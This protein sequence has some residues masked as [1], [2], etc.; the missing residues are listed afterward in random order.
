MA[1]SHRAVLGLTQGCW[2]ALTGLLAGSHKI[3]LVELFRPHM[4]EQQNVTNRWGVG[5]QHDQSIDADADASGRRQAVLERA[6]VIV[7]E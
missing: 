7:V 5:Q 2:R 4:R 6:N 1:G 3:G